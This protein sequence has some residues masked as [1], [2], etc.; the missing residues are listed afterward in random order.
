MKPRLRAVLTL[1]SLLLLPSACV[2]SALNSDDKVELTGKV[3]NE[4]GSPLTSGDVLLGRDTSS[5]CIIPDV[6]A[7][8]ALSSTG[9]FHK[10]LAGADTQNGDNARC[11]SL[12]TPASSGGGYVYAQFLMQVT[13]VEAPTMQLW[14]GR[15]NTTASATGTQLSF[16]D[17][18]STHGVTN[19]TYTFS[20]EKPDGTVWVQDPSGGSV[21]VSD[22]VMEDFEQVKTSLVAHRQVKG[23]GTTFTVNYYANPQT[24][25]S[26]QKLPVSRGAACTFKNADGTACPFTDGRMLKHL[27]GPGISEVT[28][29]LSGPKALR[30]AVFRDL[31][32]DPSVTSLVL[33]GSAD[34]STWVTLATLK[35]ASSATPVSPYQEI[36]LPDS[37]PAVSQVRLRATPASD[38]STALGNLTELSLFE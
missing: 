7:H 28:I 13:N 22:Y 30:R 25:A 12:T 8:L 35:N 6:Y 10:D 20:L 37:A 14:S 11:F 3:L 29:T 23:S 32:V 9:E 17:L 27:F 31:Q 21:T 33:E 4:D 18:S 1:T 34:G 19:A 38:Q 26:K 2:Q 24:L 36:A 15:I 5:T 16:N